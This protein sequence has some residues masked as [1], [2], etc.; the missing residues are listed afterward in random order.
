MKL[1]LEY[2]FGGEFETPVSFWQFIYFTTTTL[3][4]GLL[5][6]FIIMFGDMI[7]WNRVGLFL[8]IWA[9]PTIFHIKGFKK[10][11]KNKE[12]KQ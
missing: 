7:K 9:I 5:I 12:G 2:V 11:I 10:Y 1:Y 6:E 8:I 3:V 4:F